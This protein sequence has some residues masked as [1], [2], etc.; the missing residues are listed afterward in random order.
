[1]L[2]SIKQN[3]VGCGCPRG[4]C[5]LRRDISSPPP[6]N[7]FY[8]PLSD[9]ERIK[10]DRVLNLDLGENLVG[11]LDDRSWIAA[12]AKVHENGQIELLQGPPVLLVTHPLNLE[13]YRWLANLDR[14]LYERIWEN[15]GWEFVE[16]SPGADDDA[17][18]TEIE[19]ENEP[20][21]HAEE[22]HDNGESP[23]DNSETVNILHIHV[24][25]TT[26]LTSKHLMV[27]YLVHHALRM[28]DCEFWSRSS[29]AI[30]REHFPYDTTPRLHLITTRVYNIVE[31]L[32]VSDL[33]ADNQ[34]CLICKEEFTL[35]ADAIDEY[36]MDGPECPFRLPCNHCYG[37]SCLLK[38]LNVEYEDNNPL[39]IRVCTLCNK[40]FDVVR[41]SVPWEEPGVPEVIVVD[42]PDPLQV[43]DPAL[44][45]Y[46]NKNAS[47]WWM[48]LLRGA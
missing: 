21:E 22:A 12:V 36:P 9:T 2:D 6:N 33:D 17:A 31:R 42:A 45:E 47:H 11:K 28:A 39:R 3:P 48:T 10:A 38:W 16:P 35:D 46:I 24:P 15:W 41:P 8:L 26:E 32:K 37:H 29:E 5:P 40:D 1:M 34:E 27:Y 30:Y 20:P 14:I 7:E 19:D 18:E 43:E 25:W 23:S 13:D 4:N 44:V